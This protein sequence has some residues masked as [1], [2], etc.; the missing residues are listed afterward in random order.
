MPTEPQA[1]PTRVYDD[2]DATVWSGDARAVMDNL[3]AGSVDALIT[4]PPYGLSSPP[5]IDEVLTRWEAGEDYEHT[6]AGFMSK[7]WDSFVPGPATWRSALRVV[8]PG[9]PALVFAGSRTLDLMMASLRMAGWVIEGTAHYSYGSG[10]PKALDIGKALDKELGHER[11][12]VLGVKP[13]HED[14]L[15]RTDAHSSGGRSDGWERPWRN[16]EAAVARS[17]LRFAPVSEQAKQWDGYRSNLKGA[18]EPVIIARAPGDAQSVE[19]G[20]PYSA[21]APSDERVVAYIPA[22][23]CWGD[24]HALGAD[25]TIAVFRPTTCTRCGTAY[26]EYRHPTVKPL[27]VMR[28]FIKAC[29]NGGVALDPFAGSG[30]T[31]VAALLEGRAAVLVDASPVHAAMSAQRLLDVQPPLFDLGAA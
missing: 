22:C 9:A 23:S 24:P 13:G 10:M 6:G 14:F 1:A 28:E 2:P 26:G 15:H 5:D 3:N 25:P 17:H 11:T 7:S 8:K 31:G 30:T 19:V 27:A 12:E 21:K 18:H 16:D 20:H 29:P 4:D